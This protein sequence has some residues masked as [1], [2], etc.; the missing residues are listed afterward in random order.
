MIDDRA[1]AE[2]R[3]LLDDL[4]RSDK[5]Q[6]DHWRDDD[7]PRY[8]AKC[9]TRIAAFDTLTTAL[10]APLCVDAAE[11]EK[12]REQLTIA[13]AK[14]D[15]RGGEWCAKNR[16]EGRGPCGA[17]AWCCKQATD[18]AEK[19]EAENARL[20]EALAKLQPHLLVLANK[21]DALDPT[22]WTAVLAFLETKIALAPPAQDPRPSEPKVPR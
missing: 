12:L 21:A 16:A 7:E 19:A 1:L 4:R 6:Y 11:L 20:Q 10:N 5:A 17:C 9:A 2:A 22:A 13:E 14:A 8:E 18:C 3:K 15:V